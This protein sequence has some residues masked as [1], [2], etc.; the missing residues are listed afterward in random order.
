MPVTIKL[1]TP[2]RSGGKDISEIELKEP[3]GVD[4][5]KCGMPF[6]L[7]DG[8]RGG[9]SAE[10]DTESVA[11]YIS[12]LGGIPPSA[13]NQLCAADFQAALNAVINFFTDTTRGN[14][15]TDAG[16]SPS[17]SVAELTSGS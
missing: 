10:F 17:S 6:R 2:V 1:K 11:K 13:V 14:V 5:R 7:D 8:A 12:E 3:R 9:T 4:I 15:S 16:N